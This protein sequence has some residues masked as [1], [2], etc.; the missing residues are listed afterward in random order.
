MPTPSER[1]IRAV[2]R[3]GE[4]AL[5]VARS[6]RAQDQS[7]RLIGWSRRVIHRLRRPICG[8]VDGAGEPDAILGRLRYLISNGTLPA[9]PS[10]VWAGRSPGGKRCAGCEA[11]LNAGE[12]EYEIGAH[13]LH[14]RCY[15]VWRSADGDW[16]MLAE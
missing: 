7:R 10:S 6:R 8:G 9:R 14:R 13:V 16:N 3:F 12:I 11:A 2:E 5:L 4:N 15:E 1:H